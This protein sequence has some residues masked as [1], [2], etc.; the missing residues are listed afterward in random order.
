MRMTTILLLAAA[1]LAVLVA[2]LYPRT[3]G[4]SPAVGGGGVSGNGAPGVGTHGVS[5]CSTGDSGP[6]SGMSSAPP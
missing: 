2:V 4:A 1:V 6:S 3:A 5:G